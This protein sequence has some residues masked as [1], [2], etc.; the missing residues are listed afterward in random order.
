MK[1][2]IVILG[3][4]MMFSFITPS[5]VA[6]GS[7]DEQYDF[8]GD[9]YYYKT[10]ESFA[11]GSGTEDDPYIITSWEEF[12]LMG[13]IGC[14]DDG[15]GRR[16]KLVCD[17]NR[18]DGS[19]SR[20]P[21]HI[22]WQDVI[23]TPIGSA[24]NPFQ[25]VFDGGNHKIISATM[26]YI[27]NVIGADGVVKNVKK[28][29]IGIA[30]VNYGAVE[31]CKIN[32]R[33][34][35]E[36][37]S[38]AGGIAGENY[39]A[40]R[41]CTVEGTTSSPGYYNIVGTTGIGGICGFNNGGIIEECYSGIKVRGEG[42]SARA[43]GGIAGDNSGGIIRNCLVGDAV[44]INNGS[45]AGGIAGRLNYGTVENC[46]SVPSPRGS[47]NLCGAVAGAVYGNS[48]II[49]CYYVGLETGN[50]TVENARYG[51]ESKNELI[52]RSLYTDLDFDNI[53]ATNNIDYPVL[54]CSYTYTDCMSHWAR[55][56]IRELSEEELVN[57]YGDGTFRPD[58]SITRA[59]Y[60]AMMFSGSDYY[61]D[62]YIPYTDIPEWA[63]KYVKEAYKQGALENIGSSEEI[64]G[65]DEPITRAEAAAIIGRTERG[66]FA[67][68]MFADT[69]EIPDWAAEPIGRAFEKGYISGYE[70]GS[71][72]PNNT[73]TRAEAATIL[74]KIK[75]K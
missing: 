42:L 57:G 48:E 55:E 4:I 52:D 13:E 15:R 49:N 44:I 45:E 28:D 65:A 1:R 73:L 63:E 32:T 66:S 29:R 58:N 71:F 36:I 40:I 35:K 5:Y 68:L 70:D 12:N 56:N 75:I 18:A 41:R 67:E 74:Y 7:Y 59:E 50:S 62:T 27:F 39:G 11:S 53:W 61:E 6:V 31:D 69:S 14:G 51:C 17:L 38:N 54:R 33:I 20:T 22:I 30:S 19:I 60:I 2:R 8:R 10:A 47:Y 43:V 23:N 26:D 21:N 64:F 46:I 24:D 3:I 72:R 25:G 37:T 34:S 9:G 16:F